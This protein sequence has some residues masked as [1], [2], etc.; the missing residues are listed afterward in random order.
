MTKPTRELTEGERE[1]LAWL[2]AWHEANRTVPI[3]W[4]ISLGRK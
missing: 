4:P 2:K 3:G 1:L